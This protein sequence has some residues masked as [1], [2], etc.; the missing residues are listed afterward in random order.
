MAGAYPDLIGRDP[1]IDTPEDAERLVDSS[2]VALRDVRTAYDHPPECAYV[3]VGAESGHRL[4]VA[5][6]PL[7]QRL[8]ASAFARTRRAAPSEPC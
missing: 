6:S 2:L 5:R 3:L 8:L 7:Y 1:R 4:R